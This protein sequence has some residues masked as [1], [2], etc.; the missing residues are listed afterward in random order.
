MAAAMYLGTMLYPGLGEYEMV[1]ILFA[2]H[3]F[4]F[5][6]HKSSSSTQVVLYVQIK[7]IM[8]TQGQ[9]PV[10]MLDNGLKTPKYFRREVNSTTS[11]W[12][13]KVPT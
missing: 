2:V 4:L 8:Q 11:V 3:C 7:Y 12:K 9:L 6:R 1:R 5:Y 10:T 13:L